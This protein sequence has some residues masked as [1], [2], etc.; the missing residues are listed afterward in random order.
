VT[1]FPDRQSSDEIAATRRVT[2]RDVASAWSLVLLGVVGLLAVSLAQPDRAALD[3]IDT[4]S[5]RH[6]TTDISG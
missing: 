3:S 5:C 1:H 4:P 6:A 2:L